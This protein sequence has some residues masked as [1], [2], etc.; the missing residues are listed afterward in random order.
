MGKLP[1]KTL[2]VDDSKLMRQ[3]VKKIVEK[4]QNI[5]VIG[6][7]ENGL[8][9]LNLLK[10]LSPDVVV[11]D[12]NMPVMD[13]LTTLKHMMIE[14]PVP[15]V[16]LSTLTK[17][18]ST[19]A[20]DSLKYGAVDF[21]A[22]PSALKENDLQNQEDEIALKV[23][24]TAEVEVS[25]LKLIRLSS[26]NK[27]SREVDGVSKAG[28]IIAIGAA[29]GGYGSLLKIIPQLSPDLPAAYIIVLHVSTE[30]TEAFV[31]YLD[32]CSA[33]K[34]KHAKDDEKVSS[35]AC[36]ICSG[37]EYVTLREKKGAFHLHVSP[38]PFSSRRGSIDMLMFSVAE[39]AGKSSIGVILSGEGEDGAEGICEMKAT[40]C[41]AIVQNP[42][43]SLYKKMP[44]AA[45][46]RCEAD[47]VIS[48]STIASAL[49][50][51]C[52]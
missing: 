38:A 33:V 17:E 39:L 41:A 9:A 1:I 19:V 49:I 10:N 34:V 51:C 25:K 8:D 43:N 13:G 18:G 28:K 40:G 46:K 15:T 35:G 47:F 37:E 31:G 27:P 11:L 3:A 44:Y 23:K 29:E 50:M 42:Q 32:Q 36:Y 45:L 2:I 7:A 26:Q 22:K 20:F 24:A 52:N 5:E 6:E 21:I 16:M 48:D 30:H 14:R 4:H 12:V